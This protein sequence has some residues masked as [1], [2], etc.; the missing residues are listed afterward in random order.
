MITAKKNE[1]MMPLVRHQRHH[2]LEKKKARGNNLPKSASSDAAN[3]KPR[4][5]TRGGF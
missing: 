1:K 2:R 5:R 3:V 4:S